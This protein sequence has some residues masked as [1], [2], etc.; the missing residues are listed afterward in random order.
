MIHRTMAR[1]LAFMAI[2]SVF[3]ITSMTYPVGHFAR[4]GPGLFPLLVSAILFA[5]GLVT[6]I[7]S[8]FEAPELVHFNIRNIVLILASLC[9]FALLAQFLDMAAAIVFLVFF[10]TLAGSDWSF[11]RNVKIA[12]GLIA[13]ALAFERFLGLNLHLF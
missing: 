12:A 13:I 2:A 1:G 4:S 10:A 8:R 7:R 6:V 3:G 9:G 11:V 5:I